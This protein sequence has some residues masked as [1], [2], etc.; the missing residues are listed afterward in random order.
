MRSPFVSTG[1]AAARERI[2]DIM[3][4]HGFAAYPY[5]FWHYSAGD[6]FAACIDGRLA[7]R[8]GPVSFEPSSGRLAPLPDRN[9][10]LVTP[11]E[12]IGAIQA[13]LEGGDGL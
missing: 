6:V 2:T 13:V 10:P 9:E 12:L 5:E 7:A 3:A 8:Y 4:R 11:L 1:Q